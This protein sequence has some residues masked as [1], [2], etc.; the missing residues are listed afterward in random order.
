[1]TNAELLR[2]L[3]ACERGLAAVWR[4]SFPLI[5]DEVTPQDTALHGRR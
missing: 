4:Q 1:M 5:R 3:E 2:R